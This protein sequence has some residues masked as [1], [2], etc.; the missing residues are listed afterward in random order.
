MVENDLYLHD[1]SELPRTVLL[2][3]KLWLVKDESSLK[4]IHAI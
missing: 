4:E 2:Y 3:K 1:I